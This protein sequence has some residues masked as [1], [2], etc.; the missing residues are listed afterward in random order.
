LFIAT[1]FDGFFQ[2]IWDLQGQKSDEKPQGKKSAKSLFLTCN[3]KGASFIISSLSGL[4][5]VIFGGFN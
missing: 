5:T 2:K 4:K 1:Q 3:A